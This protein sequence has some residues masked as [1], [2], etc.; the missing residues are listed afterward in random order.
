MS[1]KLT[2][3][4]HDSVYDGLYRVVG[5]RKISQFIMRLVRPHVLDLDAAYAA[6][7]QDDEREAEASEWSD[8]WPGDTAGED[9]EAR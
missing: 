9:D 8:A 2:I 3:T 6:M 7:A 1:R 4:T 5:P